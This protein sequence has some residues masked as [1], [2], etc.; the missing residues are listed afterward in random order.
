VSKFKLLLLMKFYK[1]MKKI[2]NLENFNVGTTFISRFPVFRRPC[3]VARLC[4]TELNSKQTK[5][6]SQS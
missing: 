1:K 3:L 2:R 6:E 4:A 5:K